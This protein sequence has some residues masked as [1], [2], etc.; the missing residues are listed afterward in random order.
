MPVIVPPSR[1]QLGEVIAE[2]E[3][4]GGVAKQD[5]RITRTRTGVAVLEVSDDLYGKWGSGKAT[6]VG[7]T[8][9]SLDPRE[10]QPEVSAGTTE[11]PASTEDADGDADPD[12]KTTRKGRK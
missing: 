3:S 7:L 5:F 10:L 9:E 4:L 1:N 11:Q 8:T 12:T 6:R 2:L